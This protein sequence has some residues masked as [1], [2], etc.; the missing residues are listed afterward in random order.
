MLCIQVYN[1]L[2]I[3]W[4]MLQYML[5][6]QVYNDLYICWRMLQYMLCIQVYNDLYIWEDVRIDAMYTGVQ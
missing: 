5:C 2:Y 4:R 3:C 1:D 6:I